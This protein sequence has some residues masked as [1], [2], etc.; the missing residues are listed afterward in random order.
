M[1]RQH[2][3]RAITR[4]IA[5][6]VTVGTL[7]TPLAIAQDADSILSVPAGLRTTSVSDAG[8]IQYLRYAHFTIPFDVDQSGRA[9]SEVHLWVSPDAGRSWLKHGSATPDKRS[10]EFHAA[11]EGEY[12]FAVQ[13]RDG[14]G[15]SALAAA[16][17]MRV[18]ID[19]SKPQL[20]LH[21]DANSS[22]RLVINYAIGERFLAEDSVRLAYSVDGKG[23][24]EE[25]RTGNLE[26]S[27]NGWV[28]SCEIEMPR[29]HDIE[30]KLVAS[31]MAQNLAETRARF[32][33]PRTAAA[34]SGLQLASQRGDHKDQN[35]LIIGGSNTAPSTTQ[36]VPGTA[37]TTSR[38]S[39]PSRPGESLATTSGG[40]PWN[41]NANAVELSPRSSAGWSSPPVSP[42]TATGRTVSVQ[43]EGQGSGKLSA[44]GPQIGM[45]PSGTF[46]EPLASNTA[47]LVR[48][49]PNVGYEELPV[50]AEASEPRAIE[51]QA[52]PHNA[53]DAYHSRSRSFSLDYS[54]DSL[55]GMAV[56][57]I[58]LWGTEDRGHTWQKWG[59]D[60]D[61]ES[62]FDVQVAA[63]GS[64]GFR[65][66]I[67][68]TNGLVSNRPHDGDAAD[69][70]IHVD[71]EMP[72]AKITRA[73]YGEGAEAGMLVI[74]YNC[75]DSN[76]HDR[77]VT[78]S[79]SERPAGP[80]ITIASGQPN[81]GSYSWKAAPGLPQQVFVRIQAVDR[82]GNTAEHC[83]EL[84]VNLG[85]LTP[86]GRIQGFRPI[87]PQ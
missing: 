66:V 5:S 65:M 40:V 83:L 51:V 8:P 47:P 48:A 20:Q 86:R 87:D 74:D 17:L 36:A 44:P 26:R 35:G 30:L 18:V 43:P 49:A 39:I 32:N 3:K 61:R 9:P 13:T 56:S 25:I 75:E 42:S 72:R 76:L 4:T 41:P 67:I 58:E 82:A 6:F 59:S 22:G 68:G 24:W 84:P 1:P 52:A 38:R 63:D 62:P 45:E 27:V 29:A 16:P 31:D 69:M 11:A 28:G 85:G 2:W 19:T 54:V 53:N 79:Y 46:A 64:F 60:P 7:V 34:N 10:F 71:T 70:L 81:T 37:V 57:E 21:A 50:P 14:R 77:P 73:L 33:A 55:R 12:L 78:L 23:Q 15:D 80:W